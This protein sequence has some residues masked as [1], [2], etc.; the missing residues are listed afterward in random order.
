MKTMETANQNEPNRAKETANMKLNG[1]LTCPGNDLQWFL[2]QARLVRKSGIQRAAR[3]REGVIG[4]PNGA[5]DAIRPGS[6]T[7]IL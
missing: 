1:D 6:A 3:C 4:E 7:M 5:R 2:A